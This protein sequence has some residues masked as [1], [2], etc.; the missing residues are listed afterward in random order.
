[1]RRRGLAISIL[2]CAAAVISG[3]GGP[4]FTREKYQ[5]LFVG[6]PQK[7][8]QGTL[9]RPN[10][11]TADTWFYFDTMPTYH[12]ARIYFRDGLVVAKE[13]FT[14]PAA[15]N[16]AKATSKPATSRPGA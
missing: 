5:T 12:A 10:A 8:V 9:G 14:N 4:E 7:E 3:C 13:W 15:A 2:L 1:M 16:A 6:Q 11:A